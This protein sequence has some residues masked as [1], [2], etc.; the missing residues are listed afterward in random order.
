MPV[1]PMNDLLAAYGI[2]MNVARVA[3]NRGEAASMAKGLGFPVV[4]KL[5]SPQ[6]VHKSDVGGVRLNVRTEEEAAQAFDEIQAT[7][8]KA[9][10][11]AT[12]EGVS[13]ERMI[14]GGVETIV[15]MTR[16]P[17]FGPI[18]LFGLGGVAV[19]LLRDVQVRLVPLTDTDAEEMLSGI[20]GA[21]LLTGYRGA[22]P[23]NRASL[24]DLLHRVS[25]LADEHPDLVELD[26]NPVLARPGASP[27]IA[28]DARV[29]LGA[30]E[31]AGAAPEKAT[32]EAPT[33]R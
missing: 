11:A 29:R 6:V 31:A 14:T 21:Q 17:A 16:D 20:R 10:P 26:L 18:V 1:G 2:G 30:P 9:M 22:P 33:R 24:L 12:F 15:G 8:K 4:M 32:T 7:L 28:L 3:A 25:L 5:R 13:V 27:C 23:A 19:E